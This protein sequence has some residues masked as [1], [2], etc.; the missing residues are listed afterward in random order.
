VQI[1]KKPRVRGSENL[2]IL[3]SMVSTVATRYFFLLTYL[4]LKEYTLEVFHHA[5]FLLDRPE[6]DDIYKFEKRDNYK[7]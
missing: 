7:Y 1:T 2:F 6:K 4:M 3:G 5:K